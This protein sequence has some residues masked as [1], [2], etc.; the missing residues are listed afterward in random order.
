MCSS[1]F[2]TSIDWTRIGFSQAGQIQRGGGE[3]G[4]NW[5]GWGMAPPLVLM[6]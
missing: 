4:S 3:D 6:R 2:A 1:P 5:R